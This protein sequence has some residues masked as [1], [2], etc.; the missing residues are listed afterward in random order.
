MRS[1]FSYSVNNHRGNWIRSLLLK[2]KKPIVRQLREVPEDQWEEWEQRYIRSALAIGFPLTNATPGGDGVKKH[3]P[4]SLAKMLAANKGRIFSEEHKAKLRLALS[5]LPPRSA[6]TRAKMGAAHRGIRCS[7]E[8]KDRLREINL[9]KKHS[10][11][12]RRKIG[13][14][15]TGKVFSEERR[16]KIGLALRGRKLPLETCL[17]MRKPKTEAHKLQLRL[18]HLGKT[19]SLETRNRLSLAVKRIWQTRKARIPQGQLVFALP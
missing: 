4:E 17:K 15:N 5:N 1:H 18:A 6:E 2:N 11:E 19:P 13:T 14:A 3:S 7:Q 9:G 12:T 8:V 16:Q 10:P